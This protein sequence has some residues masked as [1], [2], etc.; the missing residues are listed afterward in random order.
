MRITAASL[1]FRRVRWWGIGTPI[2]ARACVRAACCVG[3]GVAFH[4]LWRIWEG[5]GE[6]AFL[7]GEG[8]R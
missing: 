3:G 8:I 2:V 6:I 5:F 7:F 4:S 1:F